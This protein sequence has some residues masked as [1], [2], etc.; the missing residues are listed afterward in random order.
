MLVE[1]DE[2]LRCRR[3][4][5]FPAM[6]PVPRADQPW[7]AVC[8]APTKISKTTPCKVAGDRRDGRRSL[9]KQF[10]TSGKS[11]ARFYHRVI[12][13]TAHGPAHQVPGAMTPILTSA[14]SEIWVETFQNVTKAPL[15]FAWWLFA[16][17]AASDG[18]KRRPSCSAGL[19]RPWPFLVRAPGYRSQRPAA[20]SS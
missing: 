3:H 20:A 13:W 10:D 18:L 16:L 14:A 11:A 8:G 1:W 2:F 7:M 12:Y 19:R 15:F 5:T 17:I 4:R 6:S 9:R